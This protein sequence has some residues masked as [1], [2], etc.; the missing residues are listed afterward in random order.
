MDLVCVQNFKVQQVEIHILV[1]NADRGQCKAL[2]DELER[3][4][5]LTVPLHSLEDLE[6]RIQSGLRQMVILD[7]DNL[8]VDDRFVLKIRKQNPS[9]PIIGV[10]ERSYHPDLKEALS[11]QICACLV[12]PTDLEELFYCIKSFCE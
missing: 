10:S 2:C 4:K 7:L 12:K 11:S 9:L 5:F 8:P 1:V 3:E 6:N